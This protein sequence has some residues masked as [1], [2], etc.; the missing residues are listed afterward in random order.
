MQNILSFPGN[1]HRKVIWLE[2][3]CV[4]YSISAINF[5]RK[6]GK[7]M[8][9]RIS[10]KSH[11]NILQLIFGRYLANLVD[12]RGLLLPFCVVS[13]ITNGTRYRYSCSIYFRIHEQFS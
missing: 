1:N 13:F 4:T 8:P 12:L 2:S 6:F 5:N 7:E 3:I 9:C 11:R 10:L